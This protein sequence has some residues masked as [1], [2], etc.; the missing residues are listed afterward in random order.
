ME[1]S[2]SGTSDRGVRHDLKKSRKLAQIIDL[3][4]P[5][6]GPSSELGRPRSIERESRKPWIR[7]SSLGCL[8][9][10]V[11]GAGKDDFA[12]TRAVSRRLRSE[13]PA[14]T[15]LR[16]ISDALGE[17]GNAGSVGGRREYLRNVIKKCT[18]PKGQQNFKNFKTRNPQEPQ[19]IVEIQRLEYP[20]VTTL[21][22]FPARKNDE[23]SES[24]GL[25][26]GPTG[27]PAVNLFEWTMT[28]PDTHNGCCQPHKSVSA[29]DGKDGAAR[30]DGHVGGK[31]TP[32]SEPL[33]R[34]NQLT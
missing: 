10:T 14:A 4:P 28:A 2:L 32:S 13:A 23:K 9:E 6:R 34:N 7:G 8:G 22:F 5:Q 12:G 21:R 26:N 3:Y 24:R 29:R 33:A 17:A 27:R 11:P 18:R 19:K 1:I 30:R 20:V 31:R 25:L 15:V 16:Y